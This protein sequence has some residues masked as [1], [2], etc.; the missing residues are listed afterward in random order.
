MSIHGL[1]TMIL[2]RAEKIALAMLLLLAFAAY[3]PGLQSG[4]ILDDFQNLKTL[5][6]IEKPATFQQ[7]GSVVLTN[8]SGEGGRSIAMFTF[9]AQYASWP[10]D[11]AAFKTVNL[12]I[13]LL[14]GFLLYCFLS[15]LLALMQVPAPR[16]SW[17]AL[18]VAALWLLHP[19]QVSTVLYVVQRMTELSATFTLLGLLSYL[20][21]RQAVIVRPKYGYMV[22]TFGLG[23]FGLLAALSKENGVLLLLYVWVLELTLLRSL[24]IPPYWK[25]W[26]ALLALPVLALAGYFAVRFS[27]W[28]LPGGYGLRDFTLGQRLLT[29]ARALSEYLGLLL[30][31]RLSAFGLFHDDYILSRSLI[32][33]PGTVAAIMLLLFLFVSALY[34]RKRYPVYAFAV[35]WFFAG[36]LLESTMIPLELYFEHRNY[37]PSA[38]VF[39]A[40]GYGVDYLAR[41][42][43]SK[44]MGGLLMA[45]LAV[46]VAIL[47]LMT[48]N[49]SRLWGDPFTQTVMWS[50]NHPDS[51]RAKLQ[52]AEMKQ[53]MGDVRGAEDIYAEASRNEPGLYPSW[54]VLACSSR[55]ISF[56]SGVAVD[57]L[58]SARFSK[59]PFGGMEQLVIGKENGTC[60]NVSA[61][62]VLG[63][64]DALLE[65]PN[66]VSRRPQYSVLKGRWL[67]ADRQWK[68]A[69]ASFDAAYH[70]RPNVE[71]AL[72]G[73]KTLVLSGHP[74]TAKRYL[75]MAHAA[76]VGGNWF[77]RQ[78]YQKDIEDWEKLLSGLQRER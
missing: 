19:M 62:T 33:P 24:P 15:R 68:A 42:R 44:Q 48:W 75:D 66:F 41:E 77:S 53:G 38:G 25:A 70:L 73:V 51:L 43:L 47:A 61:A 10:D 22:M 27:T 30:L 45:F 20:A 12:L 69:L 39:F 4:F 60:A 57:A 14:N 3:F 9:A 71:V 58:H 67:A 17:L 28:I 74:E 16:R 32:D 63:L 78:S 13:H 59:L 11:P 40:L 2:S 64:F 37:L 7:L 34:V 55:N 72:L 26:K 46:W 1:F 54:L 49:E 5:E 50:M 56:P 6:R 21:G 23:A 35:L 8:P 29:E 18:S 65:N 76:N 36:H 31:P 52:L